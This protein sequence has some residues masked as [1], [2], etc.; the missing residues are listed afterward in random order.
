MKR[1]WLAA[2]LLLGLGCGGQGPPE[3]GDVKGPWV[4]YDDADTLVMA[5]RFDGAGAWEPVMFDPVPG[6]YSVATDG[7]VTVLH[8]VLVDLVGTLNGARNRIDL[9][10]GGTGYI[11]KVQNP[12]AL[13][14]TWEGTIDSTTVTFAVDSSGDITSLTGLA[15]FQTGYAYEQENAGTLLDVVYWYCATGDEYEQV[16]FVGTKVVIGGVNLM[17]IYFLYDGDLNQDGMAT[18]TLQ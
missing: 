16:L 4:Q 5:I 8:N 1:T 11:Q 15:D 17:G 2:I 10:S 14:G 13:A 9:V 18:F 6:T 12:G 3:V 7:T